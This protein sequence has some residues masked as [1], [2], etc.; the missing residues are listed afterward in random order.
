MKV[1]H[2]NSSQLYSQLERNL[3]ASKYFFVTQ[4]PQNVVWSKMFSQGLVL[5]MQH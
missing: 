2:S 4:L 5:L 3:L 1:I